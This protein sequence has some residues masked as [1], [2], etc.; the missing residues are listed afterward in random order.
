MNFISALKDYV[1]HLNAL[2]VILEHPLTLWILLK[3]FFVF[4][5]KSISLAFVYF[6]SF[7]WLTDFVE[8]PA[9][10]KQ[11]YLTMI[12]GKSVWEGF[13][14]M[15]LTKEFFPFGE[16]SIQNSNPFF[17]GFLNS[18]FL[19]L[20]LSVPHI[21]SLRAFL[22][23]GI[24]AG[25][26]SIAGTL[27]GQ[28]VFLSFV[29]FGVEFFLVPFFHL[30]GL[31]LFGGFV[32][33]INLIYKMSHSPDMRNL[34]FKNKREL[35]QFFKLNFLLGCI[36]QVGIFSFFGNLTLSPLN[37]V[38]QTDSSGSSFFITTLF[39]LFSL[40]VGSL[41][42]TSLFSFF[43]M[44][45]YDF[46]TNTWFYTV[47]FQQLKER[48]HYVCLTFVTIFC[49]NTIP[50]Y[51]WDYL[52]GNSFG[53][54]Y[55]DQSFNPIKPKLYYQTKQ[56]SEKAEVPEEMVVS[57]LPFDEETSRHD[58]KTAEEYVT[59]EQSHVN[60]DKAWTNRYKLNRAD[61]DS[62]QGGTNAEQKINKTIKSSTEAILLEIP[63]YDTPGL[64]NYDDANQ[65]KEKNQTTF[66]G[67]D[68]QIEKFIHG[69]FRN[70]IDCGYLYNRAEPNEEVEVDPSEFTLVQ[71]QFRQ[72]YLANPIYKALTHLNMRAFLIGQIPS[73]NLTP[74]DEAELMRRRIILENYINSLSILK[75]HSHKSYAEKVYNHQFKGTLNVLRRYQSV[76]IN[77]Y[78]LVSLENKQVQK[79][80]LKFD[81][82]KYNEIGN[83]SKMLLHEELSFK[84]VKKQKSVKQTKKLSRKE[85][86]ELDELRSFRAD[87]KDLN[88]LFLRSNNTAPFYIGWDKELRKFLVKTPS[89]PAQLNAGDRSSLNTEMDIPT[90]Y[91]FQ[92]WTP[93]MEST[94]KEDRKNLTLPT[95]EL[96]KD[97]MTNLSRIF[98][99]DTKEDENKNE[100]GKSTARSNLLRNLRK[101]DLSSIVKRAPNYDW[102]WKRQDPELVWNDKLFLE[103]GDA[104][105]PKLDGI[106]WPGVQNPF[107]S[108]NDE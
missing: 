69:I 12:E 48:I 99:L 35:N 90:S 55:Q 92:A 96:S 79:K 61:A 74:Y 101:K 34:T 102:Y 40:I 36:E 78:D 21:L 8:L 50:Y 41:L 1:D 66:S 53:F 80:V 103:L 56:L 82:P 4:I 86:K 2:Q 105:P 23:H 83:E 39:Y 68:A 89:V 71:R 32:L 26:Y 108:K 6:I 37:N 106:T 44:K 18:F 54:I 43:I 58:T 27:L 11:N 100:M 65:N 95:S 98:N 20:P 75:F 52:V 62:K 33:L 97:Q 67:E 60:P 107:L 73:S 42:W 59:Y 72:K 15:K 5:F 94:A 30:D 87:Y 46:I 9:F 64:K 81:Q 22:I 63:F 3:S 14:Q 29:L 85:L 84:P 25:I 57:S 10:F 49:F 31:I 51:G 45:S 93:L 104:L 19:A 91:S 17:I 70:D 77:D 7:K 13:L 24:P 38:M 88:R 76:R 47:S 28:I 16:T